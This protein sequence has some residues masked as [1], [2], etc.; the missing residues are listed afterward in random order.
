MNFKE[1]YGAVDPMELAKWFDLNDAS[2]LIAPMRNP[3]QMNE[4]LKKYKTVKEVEDS[5]ET[6]YDVKEDTCDTLAKTIVLDWKG[7]TDDDGNDKVYS[8]D[9]CSELLF[10]YDN[11]R[12]WVVNHAE[13][14]TKKDE[15]KKEAIV[16]K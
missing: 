13:E 15:D 16:K 4:G 11:F 12:E 8:V 7:I 2:F 6:L 10:N 14:L 9:Y 3:K 1:T 5:T